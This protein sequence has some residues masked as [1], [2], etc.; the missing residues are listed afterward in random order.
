MTKQKS[1]TVKQQRANF[2][3]L[4]LKTL[5]KLLRD[6]GIKFAVTTCHQA[7]NDD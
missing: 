7:Q 1:I 4:K 3:K 5:K 2:R 6:K